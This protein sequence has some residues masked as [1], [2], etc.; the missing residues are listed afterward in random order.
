MW[1]AYFFFSQQDEKKKKN[2]YKICNLDAY[3]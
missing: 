1:K 3:N 2:W